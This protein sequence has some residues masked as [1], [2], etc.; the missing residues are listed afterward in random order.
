MLIAIVVGVLVYLAAK[1]YWKTT[2]TDKPHEIKVDYI[3]VPVSNALVV[4][5][6]LTPILVALAS[7]LYMNSPEA[8]YPS[9]LS[10]IVLMFI[11]LI[12]AVWETHAILNV[13]STTDLIKL[14]MPKDRAYIILLHLIYAYLTLGLIYFAIFFLF[15][16]SPHA[17]KGEESKIC[18][19]VTLIKPRVGINQSKEE[20]VQS[21]GEPNTIDASTSSFEYQS[22]L[23]TVQLIFD[24]DGKLKE[25][26]ELR[27][28]P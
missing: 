15:E 27:S 20:V 3:R 22:D 9:L 17:R 24:R 10:T 4:L 25:I 26:I 19:P 14:H 2:P 11:V 28:Q 18:D 8:N 12:I 21:W 16:I 23:S 13:A 7:Y 1:L 6:L 5:G